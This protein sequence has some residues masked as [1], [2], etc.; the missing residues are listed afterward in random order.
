VRDQQLQRNKGKVPL[1]PNERQP[2]LPDLEQLVAPEYVNP[3]HAAPPP[4]AV[5]A[6][7]LPEPTT[8]F[9]ETPAPPPSGQGGQ[10]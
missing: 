9:G 5:P 2:T 6:P 3:T 7:V 1:M 10:P 8:P 4:A